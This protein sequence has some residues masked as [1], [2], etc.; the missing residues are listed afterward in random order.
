MKTSLMVAALLAA[1]ALTS[2]NAATVTFTVREDG[3]AVTTLN[4]GQ[5]FATAGPVTIGDFRVS[6]TGPA[7]G[8]LPNPGFLLSG[9]T[10]DL[11]T[12]ALGSHTLDIQVLGVGLSGPNSL[13]TLASSFDTTAL[14]AGWTATIASDIN[15]NIIASHVFPGG[16]ASGFDIAT[17]NFLPTTYNASIDFH[18]V[19]NG[20]GGANLGGTLTTPGQFNAVPGPIAGAGLPGLVMAMI[21]LFGL[22]RRRRN[23][24]AA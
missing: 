24:L 6:A 12:T 19:T 18:I 16:A 10:I 20:A 23:R 8:A 13:Q 3:G 1:T 4:T 17:S 22:N 14:S 2:A 5:D 11:Q 21:G 7:Q 9:Q 15:N